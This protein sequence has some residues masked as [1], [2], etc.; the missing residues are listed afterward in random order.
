M[1]R[2]SIGKHIEWLKNELKDVD[3]D[4][5]E[6][7]KKSPVW[8]AKD[9]LLQSAPGVGDG[10]SRTLI[11]ELPELGRLSHKQISA[12]VGVAPLARDSGRFRGRRSIWG[13]RASV[14]SILYMATVTAVRFNPAIREFHQ[15]LRARGKPPKVALT[16]CMHKF[17]TILNAM[18]RDDS[19]WINVAST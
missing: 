10:L 13:G 4:L 7:I 2:K 9:K 14:R 1:V 3:R 15:R 19:P 16:A 5:D 6:T 12:L 17:L 8:R 18:M 11:S